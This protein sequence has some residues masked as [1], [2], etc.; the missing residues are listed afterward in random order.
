VCEYVPALV[1][2]LVCIYVRVCP[3]VCVCVCDCVGLGVGPWTGDVHV[4]KTR[5]CV[6]K[7]LV[8]R[9]ST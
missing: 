9:M 1:C 6:K 3:C 7:K 4:H 5:I 8:C 2:V